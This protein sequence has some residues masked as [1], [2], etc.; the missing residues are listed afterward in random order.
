MQL[1]QSQD[2]PQRPTADLHRPI[3][4]G[5]P[6]VTIGAA[7]LEQPRCSFPVIRGST[8]AFLALGVPGISWD[9]TMTLPISAGI[10]SQHSGD[11]QHQWLYPGPVS[12]L[13]NL[14]VNHADQQTH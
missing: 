2:P 14:E 11:L 13:Q 8:C 4:A 9:L 12:E 5:H 10:P 1:E 3:L 6:A 7:R